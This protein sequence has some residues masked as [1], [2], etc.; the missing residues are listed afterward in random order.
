MSETLTV[1]RKTAEVLSSV[2]KNVKMAS[3]SILNLMPK[4]R[5]EQLK[6]EMTTQLSV[7]DAFASRAAKMLAEEGVKPEEENWMTRMGAKWGA[8]MNTMR[9]STSTHLAEM[10]VEGATMGVNDMLRV[11]REAENSTASESAVKL[12]RD[13]CA[14]EEKLVDEMRANFLR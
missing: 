13:V 2:Y 14:Y 10:L 9:D 4:V 6:G 5:D 8:M 1:N 3:D 11:L 12:A 7:F